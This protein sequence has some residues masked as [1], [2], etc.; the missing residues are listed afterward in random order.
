MW[1]EKLPKKGILLLFLEK[2]MI[3]LESLLRHEELSSDNSKR[4]PWFPECH[5]I[6]IRVRLKG[7]VILMTTITMM[8]W[9]GIITS[10]LQALD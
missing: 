9:W 8:S 4:F 5:R 10:R 6:G 1:C 2:M 7:K 3:K